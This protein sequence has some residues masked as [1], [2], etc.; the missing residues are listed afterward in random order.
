MN[1]LTGEMIARKN[2]K[3]TKGDYLRTDI[4]YKTKNMKK[5]FA[6]QTIDIKNSTQ[7]WR[8]YDKIPIGFDD[9]KT[10]IKEM[11]K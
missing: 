1:V 9:A 11:T 4:L 7:L 2:I 5:P 3:N 10:R 6:L 8:Y